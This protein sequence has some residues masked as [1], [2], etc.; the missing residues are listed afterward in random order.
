MNATVI[1]GL[2]Q[3]GLTLLPLLLQG[4]MDIANTIASLQKLAQAGAAGTTIS[5]ADLAVIE[6]QFDADL[7]EFNSPL[8]DAPT[9]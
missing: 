7:T 3:K 9:T 2:I 6:A 8:P 5:D 4:G 1:F